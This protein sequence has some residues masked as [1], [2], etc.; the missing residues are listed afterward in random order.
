MHSIRLTEVEDTCKK[1]NQFTSNICQ[2]PNSPK[3]S[4]SALSGLCGYGLITFDSQ[5]FAT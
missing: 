2:E 3:L 1:T 5:C 4:Q